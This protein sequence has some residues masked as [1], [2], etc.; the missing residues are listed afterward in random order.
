MPVIDIILN[1]VCLLLWLNWR[2]R[3]MIN[4]PRVPGL[5]L[6]GTLTRAGASAPERWTSP[7]ALL[8]I[9]LLRA[10]IYAQVGHSAR[11][12]PQISV[13][14]FVLPFRPDLFPHMLAYSLLNFLLCAGAFYF[15][16]LLVAG[17]NRGAS[18]ADSWTAL[19]R[20]HLG[21]L[22]R[23]PGWLCLVAPFVTVLLFW[24][25]T[26]PLLAFMAI[27]A[28][29]RSFNH[30]LVQSAIVGLGGWLLWQYLIV[31]VLLLHLVSSYVF[32]GNAP[33]WSFVAATARGLLRPLAPLP[34]RIGK[35]DL[36][37]PFALA[38]AV[39]L[40]LHVPRGL[41]WLYE[42]FAV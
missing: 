33:V 22:G 13:A 19:A 9:L 39:T 1:C 40:A 17:V 30:L 8:V 3:R 7:L 20:M 27:H 21:V 32:L 36:R 6:I 35:I 26:G 28:P 15:S 31:I 12:H 11:W 34:L 29:I 42:R 18:P 24:M 10:V 23:C 38:A 2:S 16:L 41:A 5:A 4:V 14:A 25:L 37:P